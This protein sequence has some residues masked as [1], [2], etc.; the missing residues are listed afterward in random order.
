MTKPII[1]IKKPCEVNLHSMPLDSKGRFCSVCQTTVIDFTQ[2]STHEIASY[3][4]TYKSEK[5]CGIFKSEI[6]MTDNNFDNLISY[7]HSKKLRF[8]AVLITGVLILTGCKTKKHTGTT[9]G[10]PRFLDEKMNPIENVK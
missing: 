6:V 7:L 10:G 1:E 8:V 9:Y 5:V 4:Q 3:F 2:K